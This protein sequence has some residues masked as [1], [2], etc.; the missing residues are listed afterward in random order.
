M[1]LKDY[2]LVVLFNSHCMHIIL[3][4]QYCDDKY[5]NV[6]YLMISQKSLPITEL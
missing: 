6:V 3:L 1:L 4:F 5:Q 2:V